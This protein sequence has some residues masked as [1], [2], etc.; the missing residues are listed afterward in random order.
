MRRHGSRLLLAL[1]L[2]GTV[3]YGQ[4]NAAAPSGDEILEL[5]AKAEQKVSGFETA[6]GSVKPELDKVDPELSEKYVVA[7]SSARAIITS[8]RKTG[9]SAYALAA[10]VTTLDD[11]SLDATTAAMQ[12]LL[13]RV[14]SGRGT[15]SRLDFM[16]PVPCVR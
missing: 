11:L 12:L 6:V 7:A 13:V 10:L 2:S 9:P 15:D 5:L 8:V 3:G 1:L 4:K 14:R 16:V